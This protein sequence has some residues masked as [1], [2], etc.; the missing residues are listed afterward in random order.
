MQS[1]RL[2]FEF[3]SLPKIDLLLMAE[4][5]DREKNEQKTMDKNLNFFILGQTD[6]SI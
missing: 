4:K 3:N 2:L 1:S 6:L 5:A